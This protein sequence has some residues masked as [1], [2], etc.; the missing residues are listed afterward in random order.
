VRSSEPMHGEHYRGGATAILRSQLDA[1]EPYFAFR[2]STSY[3]LR[4]RKGRNSR[5]RRQHGEE[6]TR[7]R[8][9][10]TLHFTTNNFSV[11]SKFR[12]RLTEGSKE[13]T[14]PPPKGLRV[15]ITPGTR[16]SPSGAIYGHGQKS[17]A[18]RRIIIG[19]ARAGFTTV[20]SALP[21]PFK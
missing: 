2:I 12:C 17:K 9:Q 18:L 3:S 14:T 10:R 16:A 11:C 13:P 20:L 7:M 4:R 1:P 19:R 21:Y 15:A 5:E 8:M 6:M